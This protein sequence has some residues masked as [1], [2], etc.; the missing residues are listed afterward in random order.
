MTDNPLMK[1]D[2]AL[3]RC[4][5]AAFEE[6][7]GLDAAR[8]DALTRAA[9]QAVRRRRVLRLFGRWGSAALVAA[10][11]AAALCFHALA[12]APAPAREADGLSAA[13]GLLCELDGISA[14]ERATMS[15]SELLLAWQEA[16]CADLL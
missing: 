6:G 3:T 8:L 4:I 7:E 9:E 16:P 12:P 5:K 2:T 15:T 14:G 1:E 10:S 13:I 11:I